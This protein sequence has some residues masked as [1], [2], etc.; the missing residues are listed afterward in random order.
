M[1]YLSFLIILSSIGCSYG[2]KID[3]SGPSSKKEKLSFQQKKLKESEPVNTLPLPE[4][5]GEKNSRRINFE[6]GNWVDMDIELTQITIHDY[7]QEFKKTATLNLGTWQGKDIVSHEELREFCQAIDEERIPLQEVKGRIALFLNPL[8]RFILPRIVL[9][10]LHETI[11]N[12][13]NPF[14]IAKKSIEIQADFLDQ[15]E[16]NQVIQEGTL[17]RLDMHDHLNVSLFN[18]LVGPNPKLSSMLLRL[19]CGI[20][21]NKASILFVFHN[22]KGEAM[23]VRINGVVFDDLVY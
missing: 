17:D 21:E 22:E 16:K 14:V 7:V 3:T 6:S 23:R 1:K 12:V 19:F 9:K 2:D 4:P 10:N 5:A 15:A 20:A 11:T 18:P 8:H 13:K